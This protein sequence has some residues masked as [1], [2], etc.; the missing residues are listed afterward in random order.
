MGGTSRHPLGA[1][2]GH[3]LWFCTR[4]TSADASWWASEAHHPASSRFKRCINKSSLKSIFTA[5]IN[6]VIEY[7][8][9]IYCQNNVIF[10]H[11]E[12]KIADFLAFYCSSNNPHSELQIATASQLCNYHIIVLTRTIM[13]NSTLKDS[14]KT[15][16]LIKDRVRAS[17][18]A[19]NIIVPF[20]KKIMFR[21]SFQYRSIQT[22][23][24]L[25]SDLKATK[26][27]DLFK[28]NLKSHLGILNHAWC[29]I[30]YFCTTMYL[31]IL[32]SLLLLNFTFSSVLYLCFHFSP[33]GI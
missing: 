13:N 32:I 28:C 16:F 25:P 8:L 5:I 31:C 10:T 2:R 21:N 26:S 23:N 27:I 12:S 1:R 14:V 6:S 29:L 3:I 24:M 7:A 22:W 15:M 33:N 18:Y 20:F 17:K 9:P 30:V 4:K 19:D 11:V